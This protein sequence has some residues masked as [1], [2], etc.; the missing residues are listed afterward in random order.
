MDRETIK[1]SQS[2]RACRHSVVV[3]NILTAKKQNKKRLRYQVVFSG[4]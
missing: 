1:Y 2:K 3:G 4:H